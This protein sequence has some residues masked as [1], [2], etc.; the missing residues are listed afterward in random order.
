MSDD[1]TPMQR[2]SHRY[3]ATAGRRALIG[4][5]LLLPAA[6]ALADTSVG[7]ATTTPLLTSSAGNVTVASGGTI[8]VA[9]GTAITIDAGKTATVNSGGTL[10]V[11]SA[12]GA[13]AIVANPGLT[14]AIV[15]QGTIKVTEDFTAKVLDNSTIAAG[16]VASASSRYGIH[17][18][19]GGAFTG[20]IQNGDT[21][22]I[23]VEGLNSAGIAV[24]GTLTGTLTN[25]GT[26]TIK[27]DGSVGIRTAAVSGDVN[28][29]GTITTVGQGT[30]AVLVG[31][32]VGGIVKLNGSLSNAYTYTADDGTTQSLSRAALSAGKAL[33]EVDG[34]VAGGVVV[35]AATSSTATDTSR[36]VLQSYGNGPTLQI[37]G[38]RDIT[39]GGGTTVSGTYSVGIDGS[40]SSNA[41][42]SSTDS[43]GVAIGGKGGNVTLTKGLAVSGT[44]SAT[45][46]DA[47]AAAI[48][49]ASGSN[50]ASLYNSGT[51][52]ATASQSG[53]G[54]LYGVKDASGTL[55]ALTNTGYITVSGTTDGRSA[56][57]D[58]SANTSGV[59]V[60]QA[61]N[62]TT[63]AS[64]TTDKAASGYNPDTATV[65]TGIS[66]DIYTGSGNDTL[67]IQ[68]GK[69]VGNA[70]L[71]AGNNTVKL[72]DDA[73]WIGNIDFGSAGTATMTMAG[74]SRFTGNLSLNG[75]V[76]TLTLAD[77]SRWLGTVTGGSQLTVNVNSGTFGA[78]ASTTSSIK[79]LNVGATGTLQVYIDGAKGTSSKLIADTATF[80]SG[81]KVAAT[82]TSLQQGNATYTVL[83]AGTLTGGSNLTSSS[84]A[85]PVL[86]KGSVAAV[87]NTVQLTVARKTAA[88]LGLTAP[89]AA[90]YD[91]IVHNAMSYT[92]LE[93]SLLQVSDSAALATQFNEFLPD[94]AGGTF[95]FV[96]R[97]SRLATQ[98]ID[99]DSSIYTISDVGGW[100]EPIYFNAKHKA[101]ATTNRYTTS[102]FGITA[103]L[104]KV[105]ALGNF[106]GSFGFVSG[107]VKDS[108][109][110]E[111]KAH[112]IELGAFWRKAAGPLYAF[113]RVGIGRGTF[114]SAR[115]F[116]G[117]AD[118][119]AF[120]YSAAGKWKG[121]FVDAT[122]GL[123]YAL[124]VGESLKLKPKAVVEYYRLREKGYTETGDSAIALTV[125]PR[126]S[127]AAN[128]TTTL[129][130]SWSAGPS[131]YEGRAFTVEV[132]AGRRSHISGLLGDTHASFGSGDSFT[133]SPGKANSAWLGNVSILQGGLDYT[134]RL[135]AGAERPQ[136][137]GTAY[138]LRASLSFAM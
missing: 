76:G 80:A 55:T 40:V 101:D 85:M 79:T 15:N 25:T 134:W 5:A 82:I 110:N 16:P 52:K 135:S 132:E 56:A 92:Y 102:G 133:L 125:D 10:D 18:L 50:V 62:A 67:D 109:Y 47:G 39:I 123:S 21:G 120:T 117:T 49:I 96:T 37:G 22:T 60:K 43:Y 46:V 87:G 2:N 1:Q 29:G 130:A 68:S 137:G 89:Q 51:I 57:I 74:N 103:G 31:G 128:A 61:L 35:Y 19:S 71:G 48:S 66:G 77:S 119:A 113:A 11:G 73:K 88:E 4:A 20:N 23:T 115:T 26:I 36:G 65:Y 41:Y 106:G 70:Y 69:I 104:E 97:G 91:A 95:D 93:K 3:L 111:V 131:S 90:A 58:L 33:V 13:S 136:G 127:K 81:S 138:S 112:D 84:L 99:N 53:F 121:T 8:K 54:N 116:N 32:D 107:N 7:S 24:D 126:T 100:F 6:P 63:S 114:T 124:A 59:T 44:V 64:Q 9:S 122:A 118:T 78:N 30:Q 129:A 86:Y 38:T 27:G 108:A 42:Y 17:V 72:A 105:T 28:A 12:N 94:F 14:S 34:N 75:Q 83:S 98:H 45:T